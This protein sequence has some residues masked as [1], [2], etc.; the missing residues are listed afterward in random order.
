MRLQKF[1]SGSLKP[2]D[3]ILGM[4]LNTIGHTSGAKT[5]GTSLSNVEIHIPDRLQ[6]GLYWNWSQFDK[7]R[8]WLRSSLSMSTS[9]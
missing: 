9:E 8:V 5:T 3:V 2:G 1:C 6:S 4:L 7:G